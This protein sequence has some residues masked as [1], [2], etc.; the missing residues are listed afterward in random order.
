MMKKTVLALMLCAIFAAPAANTAA[1]AAEGSGYKA[2][3]SADCLSGTVIS[4]ENEHARYP[5]ASMCKIMT[6]LLCFEAHDEGRLDLAEKIPVSEHAAGMGGSQ[7]FL[8]AGAEYTAGDLIESI[9]VASAND[10]CVAMAER[11]FGSEG[12]FVEKM[13]GRAAELG[14]RDTCF[15]NCTGL[16]GEGQYSSAADVA[17]MFRALLS[18]KEYFSYSK[19]WTDTISHPKGRVTEMANTNKLI[20]S[21]TGC[22]AGKTGYTDAAGFCLAAS[23]ARG[24]MRVLS[25]VLGAESSKVRFEKTRRAFD[26]AFSGYTN[27][28][29][30]DDTPLNEV[31]P[32]RGGKRPFAAVKAERPV[33]LFCKRGEKDE[34]GYEIA[35]DKISAPVRTGQR[36]G[37]AVIYK[38]NVEADRVALVANEDVPRLSYF[39]AIRQIARRRAAGM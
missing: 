32:L 14:M 36:L 13:N 31:C 8:E 15:I 30:F 34:I 24:N 16:P 3:Y 22:D 33:Y 28:A 10:A 26:D 23:A 9:C 7:V 21:Y 29:V 35:F 12:A 19:I 39:D 6:L 11:L 25:V 37:E 17:A 38:N 5:I 1:A 2:C 4:A 20:R 27:R 18:H